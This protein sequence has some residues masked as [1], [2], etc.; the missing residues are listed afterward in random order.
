MQTA[1]F[2]AAPGGGPASCQIL[3]WPGSVSL[4]LAHSSCAA[5]ASF[6]F[7][8]KSG[9]GPPQILSRDLSRPPLSLVARALLVLSAP[10]TFFFQIDSGNDWRVKGSVKK[11]CSVQVRE[12]ETRLRPAFGWA[13]PAKKKSTP[14]RFILFSPLRALLV[15]AFL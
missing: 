2:L 7:L 8:L 3:S 9:I 5:P 15:R 10:L 12:S 6:F 14:P 1:E 11:P 13:S 4:S